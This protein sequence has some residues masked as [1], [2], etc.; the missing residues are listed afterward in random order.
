[1][2]T[3]VLLYLLALLVLP[4]GVGR[5]IRRFERGRLVQVLASVAI[6]AA[7]LGFGA[8]TMSGHNPAV[9]EAQA[10]WAGL[11]AALLLVA[12]PAFA[13]FQLGYR[14]RS[15]VVLAVVWISALVPVGIYLLIVGLGVVVSLSCSNAQTCELFN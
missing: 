12:L 15:R 3:V 14:V 10:I 5:A 9:S 4:V 8:W 2:N 1:M 13:F 7:G 11:R 6:L